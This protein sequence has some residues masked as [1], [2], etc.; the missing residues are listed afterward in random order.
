MNDVYFRNISN[1]GDLCLDHIFF[2]F[3]GEPILFT[4]VDNT[5]KMY[6]CVC[7]EMRFFQ[8]WIISEC[9]LLNLAAMIDEKID[10]TTAFL[11][12]NELITIVSDIHGQETIQVIKASE[13]DPLD[14]PQSGTFLK[15]N[16]DDSRRYLSS[17]LQSRAYQTLKVTPSLQDI[18]ISYSSETNS[19]LNKPAQQ[20][21]FS[22][23]SIGNGIFDEIER[24]L[25]ESVDHTLCEYDSPNA[26][27]SFITGHSRTNPSNEQNALAA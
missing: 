21:D 24:F 14:L 8:K 7:S 4:C 15:Y 16:K 27:V 26:Y 12:S 2:E 17:K 18:F 25:K 3:D 6:L 9:S 19:I 23:C 5:S 11:E 10:I 1:V 20:V 13:I 22:V